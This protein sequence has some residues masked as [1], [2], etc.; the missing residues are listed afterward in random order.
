MHRSDCYLGYR[1]MLLT[2]HTNV[3]PSRSRSPRRFREG[4]QTPRC[5]P[6]AV[7]CP[8]LWLNAAFGVGPKCNPSQTSPRHAQ[9]RYQIPTGRC[10]GEQIRR[11]KG[12]PNR[13]KRAT[14]LVAPMFAQTLNPVSTLSQRAETTGACISTL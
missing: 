13:A 3:R 10:D 4:W 2:P 7:P 9:A 5:H 6:V 11:G 12:R 1:R 14:Q 8:S